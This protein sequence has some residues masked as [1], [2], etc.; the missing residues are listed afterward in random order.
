MPTGKPGTRPPEPEKR[1]REALLRDMTQAQRWNAL[2][3][4]ALEHGRRI[5][6]RVDAAG[7]VGGARMK[8]ARLLARGMKISNAK[9]CVHRWQEK[10]R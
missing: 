6:E 3:L 1:T 10:L 8:Y 5:M 2:I 7:Y 9:R 4:V